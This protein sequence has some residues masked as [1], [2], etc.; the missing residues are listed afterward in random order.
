LVSAS[1]V[2]K[3]KS[4]EIFIVNIR[5][6]IDRIM[7]EQEEPSPQKPANLDTWRLRVRKAFADLFKTPMGVPV[8]S[9][10]NFRIN[11]DPGAKPPD[12]QP[13]RMSDSESL[14][15]E[16]QIAQLVANCWVTDSQSQ[17]AA[18]L[19]FVKKLNGSGWRMCV[20]YRGRDAITTRDRYAL[21]YTEHL[22][23]RLH[24]S[25]VFTKL[26]LASGYHQLGIHTDKRHK[27]AFVAPDGFYEW[28]VN[29]CGLD[30]APSAFMRTMHRILGPYKKFGIVF[31]DDVL[32][33][34]RSFAKYKKNDDAILLAIRAAH[35]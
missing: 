22:I 20:N 10:N 26:N 23:D 6:S 24:G 34:S 4:S 3:S 19:R 29:P 11:T 21:T 32:I 25:R 9:K 33:F 16:T 15:F 28:T 35:L 5:E 18:G 17:F 12:R 8:A 30:N 1:F 2:A 7:E 14:E 27:T 13:Y 31:V